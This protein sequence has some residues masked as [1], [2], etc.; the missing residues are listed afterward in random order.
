M[1]RFNVFCEEAGRRR[2]TDG[3][4][5]YKAYM[6]PLVRLSAPNTSLPLT[7]I[8]SSLFPSRSLPLSILSSSLHILLLHLPPH[9]PLLHLPLPPSD[10]SLGGLSIWQLDASF[11][12]R[13]LG[14]TR[15]GYESRVSVEYRCPSFPSWWRLGRCDLSFLVTTREMWSFL[16]GG[17]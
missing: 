4:F 12:V 10:T 8:C 6:T 7:T 15:V 14:V 16:P 13:G 9:I 17:D 2:L 11:K 3:D 5:R 1:T